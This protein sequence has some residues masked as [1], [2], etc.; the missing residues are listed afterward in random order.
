M[1]AVVFTGPTLNARDA[2]KIFPACYLPPVQHGDVY[3]VASLLQPQ[4][5]VIIDGYFNQVPAVWHKEILWA[6]AQGIQVFGTASMG[7]LRAAELDAFGMQGSGIIYEAYRNGVYP[8][9]HEQAFE[10]DDEV[11]VIHGPKELGYRPA[12]EAMVNI[13]STLAHA[14]RDGIVSSTTRDKLVNRAK[15]Q[16]YAQ[17]SFPGLLEL[18]QTAE[19][20]ESEIA[21]LQAW[22]PTGRMDQ[23][24]EDADRLLKQL[25]AGCDQQNSELK[26]KFEHTTLWDSAMQEMLRIP[27]DTSPLLN[28]LRL[29]GENYFTLRNKILTQAF[30]VDEELS[31]RLNDAEESVAEL[32]QHSLWCTPLIEQR[33]KNHFRN[34][35]PWPWINSRMRQCLQDLDQY[36]SLRQRATEKT[37]KLAQQRNRPPVGELTEL[38]LLQLFDWYFEQVLDTSMPDNIEAYATQLGFSR[39]DDFHQLLLHEYYFRS[40]QPEYSQ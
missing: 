9:Y 36:E 2:G 32:E 4:I 15:Q 35:A 34:S 22:L 7:A 13:R 23:K 19:F 29:L 11:A 38:Q 3:R 1:T 24:R 8:P 10:D 25:A 40:P 27:D 18:A 30:G 14:C 12:S 31:K 28:E 26:F 6:L 16:F 20:P 21:A 17:R 37:R 39:M 33:E 5:V